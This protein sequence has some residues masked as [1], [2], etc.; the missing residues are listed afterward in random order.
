MD[1]PFR[2]P[3]RDPN[4]EKQ[5]EDAAI[6]NEW[7]RMQARGRVRSRQ[8]LV[9]NIAFGIVFTVGFALSLL[10]LATIDGVPGRGAGK[11]LAIPV[12]IATMIGLAVRKR[13]LPKGQF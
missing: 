2:Q 4:A 11:V 6:A 9:A 1:A 10:A 12:A 8:R 3:G 5:A 13:L 7:E